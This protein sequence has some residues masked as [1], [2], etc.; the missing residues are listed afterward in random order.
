MVVGYSLNEG[1]GEEKIV[2]RV[3][4]WYRLCILGDMNG[5]IGDRVRAGVTGASGIPGEN[6]NSRMSRVVDFCAE[7][8]LWGG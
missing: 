5:W 8:R 3:G 1:D 6:D 2:G 7:R 4:N